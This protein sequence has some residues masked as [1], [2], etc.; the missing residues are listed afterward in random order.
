MMGPSAGAGTVDVEGSVMTD[1]ATPEQLSQELSDIDDELADLRKVVDDIRSRLSR[2]ASG[3]EDSE[4]V[5]TELTGL[6]ETQAI[7][8]I[9]EGRRETV[10]ERRRALG[11]AD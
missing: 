2:E 11:A 1:E 8:G 7:I 9:L 5:A 10:L 3:V 6:E 4:G